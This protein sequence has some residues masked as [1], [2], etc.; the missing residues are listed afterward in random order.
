M[1]LEITLSKDIE[2][3]LFSSD[4]LSCQFALENMN[5]IS[6]ETVAG[7]IHFNPVYFGQLF[8]QETKQNFTDY[9]VEVR[10][11]EAKQLLKT[12]SIKIYEVCEK[13]GYKDIKHFYKLFKKHVGLTPSEYRDQC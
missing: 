13:V 9:L 10:V 1:L 11:E 12:T 4:I 8:K 6:L 2:G 7:Q 3:P 5:N